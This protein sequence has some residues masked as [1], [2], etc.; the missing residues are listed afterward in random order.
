[1][2]LRKNF[3]WMMIGRGVYATCQWLIIIVIARFTSPEKL[4]NFTYALAVSSPFILFSQ[5]NLRTFM[6]TDTRDQFELEDFF[7][8]RFVSMIVVMVIISFIALQNEDSLSASLII[9]IVGLYKATESI[10]DIFYGAMQKREKMS[11]IAHSVILHGISG[12]LS[13]FLIVFF[14]NSVEAGAISIFFIWLIILLFHDIPVVRHITYFSFFKKSCRIVELIK[15]CYPLGI[16]LG[17]ASLNVNIPIY[18]IKLN[19][20]TEYVGYYS[21]IAYFIIAGRMLTGSLSQAAAPRLARYYQ[22]NNATNFYRFLTKLLAVGGTVG[23]FGVIF[24]ILFGRFVLVFFYGTGYAEYSNFLNYIMIAGGIGY[25]SQFMGLTL[26]IA[27][28]FRFM[29]M[30]NLLG[31]TVTL[32]MSYIFIPS[33][34]VSAGALALACGNMTMLLFNSLILWTKIRS[35][36]K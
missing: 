26:T 29:V 24:S 4:G 30:S 25:I 6:A 2:S 5:M 28:L 10:S 7:S 20:G 36:V 12:V 8:T 11:H 18:F 19:L 31:A 23:I 14:F 16:V 3:I 33:Y 27:R 35:E 22:Q 1:M 13:M 15:S 21:A 34:G 32:I 9:F 17:L